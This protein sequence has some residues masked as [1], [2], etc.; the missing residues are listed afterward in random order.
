MEQQHTLMKFDPATGEPKPYP[1]HAEQWREWHG[2]AAAWL[3]NPWTG[4]RR[5]AG[6]VGSDTF[7]HLI[8]P[9][10]EPLYA[11]CGCIAENKAELLAEDIEC[12][13]MALDKAGVPRTDGIE[14]P[15]FSM[16]GRVLR[17]KEMPSNAEITGLSG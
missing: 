9:D 15:V 12:L 10:G 5:G 8:Q 7:G 11:G 4:T 16:W 6:D 3:F 13:H 17:F 1:S 14:G 2:K